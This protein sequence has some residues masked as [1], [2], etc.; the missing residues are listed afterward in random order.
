MARKKTP[1]PPSLAEL[2]KGALDFNQWQRQVLIEAIGLLEINGTAA[3]PASDD[4]ETRGG[5]S[6][7]P[8]R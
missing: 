5:A 6:N 7:D 3:G 1:T 8:G 2:L 4:S